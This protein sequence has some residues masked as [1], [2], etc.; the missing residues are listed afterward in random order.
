[1]AV[2]RARA[3]ELCTH[4]AS[5][6][7]QKNN[8]G[9]RARPPPTRQLV[10]LFRRVPE[11][12]KVLQEGKARILQKGNDVFYNEAQ[13]RA[14]KRRRECAR[15]QKKPVDQTHLFGTVCFA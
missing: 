12:F 13:V 6:C 15:K 3:R 8:V 7:C 2:G 1:M 11:G 5:A 9:A 14:R 10:Y 4:A